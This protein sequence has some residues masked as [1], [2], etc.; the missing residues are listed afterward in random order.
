VDFDRDHT[1]VTH[2]LGLGPRPERVAPTRGRAKPDTDL[3]GLG[4]LG[5]TRA[6]RELGQRKPS[7]E[8]Q[9]WAPLTIHSNLIHPW[10]TTHL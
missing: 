7:R 8:E 4:R 9:S 1:Q 2:R 10:H 6:P 5:H 3:V